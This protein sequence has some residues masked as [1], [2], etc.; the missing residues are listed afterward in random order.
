MKKEKKDFDAVAFMRKRRD[1]LGKLY[2]KD[3]KK[4][5]ALMQESWDDM[6]K[7]RVERKISDSKTMI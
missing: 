1:E 2:W 3:K 4:Y 5:M 7:M 6:Q